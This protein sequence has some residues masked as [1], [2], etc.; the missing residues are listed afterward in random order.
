LCGGALPLW[1]HA[2]TT[3]LRSIEFREDFRSY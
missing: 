2:C 3:R 1:L